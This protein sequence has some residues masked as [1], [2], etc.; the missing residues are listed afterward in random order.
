LGQ[1]QGFADDIPL[2]LDLF[3]SYL[4]FTSPP[5]S[6][7]TLD[8]GRSFQS[9]EGSSILDAAM[10][11]QVAL[12]YSCKVGRCSSCRCKVLSGN[13]KAFQPESGLS[14]KEKKDGWILSC[15]RTATTDMVVEVD[16]L[17]ETVLPTSKTLPCRINQLQY[18][19]PDVV[20]VLL[21]LPPTASFNFLA[22]Q[23]I[24]IIGPQGVRR[25]YSLANADRAHNQLEL[26]I[27]E[28]D[29]GVMSKYW[30]HDARVNDLL[31]LHG[32]L[33][34]FFLRDTTAIDLIFLATGTG[35]APIKA[36]LEAMND[37]PT[38]NHPKS[39][40]V[41]WGG[42]EMSDFY[43]NLTDI[44]GDHR[45]IAV[46]SRP[47]ADWKG[48]QGHVQDVL[49]ELK[50]DWQNAAVYACGSPKMISGAKQRLVQAGLPPRR[51]YSDAFVCSSPESTE[52]ER[53]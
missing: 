43:L 34:T 23:Y 5:M 30:F 13:S 18:L 36:I 15:V 48:A 9:L 26:H 27:R 25:S 35:L 40:T 2:L 49:I 16:D 6:V 33:G 32:P 7:I 45:A 21:R 39:V 38:G 19:A 46:L 47:P 22:G 14:D 24:D 17:G 3:T 4:S 20:Q 51:F 37:L 53:N 29:S 28:V 44:A 11:A 42:R 8:S 31:R 52:S 1:D 10:Q 41:L 12:P 50:P